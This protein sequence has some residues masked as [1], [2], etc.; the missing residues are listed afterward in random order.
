M[1]TDLFDVAILGAGP[2]G[3]AA[4][5]EAS[6]CRLNAILIDEQASAGGQVYRCAPGI[7]AAH[8]DPDREEGNALREALSDADIERKFGYRVWHVEKAEAGFRLHAL[9][10]EGPVT[11]TSKALVVATGALER[12][13]PFLGW[14][15]PGVM[16]LASATVLLKAQQ[17]LPGRNVV[18][19]GAGP[20]LY[21]VAKGIV[22]GGGQVAAVVDAQPRRAWWRHGR[23]LASRPDL[24]KRGYSWMRV[25]RSAGVTVLH[26]YALHSV[27]AYGRELRAIIAPIAADGS[28]QSGLTRYHVNC[29]AVC[30]GYG[31]MPDTY[32]TRLLGAAHV[33]DASLGG[34]HV[35]VD[36]DQRCDVPGLYA[37]GDVAGVVGAAAAP[38]QGR[39][40]VLSIARDLRRLNDR[41]FAWHAAADKRVRARAARF[42]KVM[43]QIARIGDGAIATLP[44]DVTMCVCER[45]QKAT[46]ETAIGDGC[47]TINDLK[48][49]TRCG[50]GPCGGRLCEDAVARLIAL[51]T[52]R[53]RAAIGQSTARPPLRPVGLDAIAGTFDYDALPMPVP[54]PL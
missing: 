1:V 48:R 25:L 19:A 54:A 21:A 36:E 39:V 22:E 13:V 40:A 20:L 15:Q 5:I 38:N 9:G 33:Y 49:A 8:A 27:V 30:C 2:A 45:V 28:P 41:E 10:P 17:M 16:G 12:Y 32:V 3:A 35:V 47:A 11:I 14:E 7:D 31:L 34:W 29:D 6:R 46:L 51:K 52:N 43:T 37:A 24:V 4:A 42:G 23:E 44:P 26:R 18:V 53:S 50:M